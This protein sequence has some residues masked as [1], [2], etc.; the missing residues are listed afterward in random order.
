MAKPSTTADFVFRGQLV[1]IRGC[2]RHVQ[3][4]RLCATGEPFTNFICSNCMEIEQANDFR[5]RVQREGRA[6][7]KRGRRD[8]QQGRRIGYLQI[9]ELA[10]QSRTLGRKYRDEKA[11]HWLMKSRVAQLKVSQRGLKL[12]AVENFNR[13]DVLSFCNNILAAHRTNAFGGKPALWDFLRD[14]ATNL[15]RVRQGHRFFKNS[16]SFAQAMRIYGGRR[17]CDL[18]TLNFGG[19]SYDCTKRENKKGVQF[20]AGEHSALF[21]AVADIYREAKANHRVEGPVPV[22]LAEDETKVKAHISWDARSD[23]LV[24]FCGVKENH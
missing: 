20:I 1:L 16:K 8:I 10:S 5:L 24:G 14:V 6:L 23:G 12:S 18:F 13:K 22:I 11:R 19:P 9:T 2:F 15:N 21:A 7:V 3:C 17:M 4:K